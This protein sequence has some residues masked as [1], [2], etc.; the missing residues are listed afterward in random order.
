MSSALESSKEFFWKV[1]KWESYTFGAR[2]FS[3]F[4]QHIPFSC[5]VS[6]AKDT[7]ATLWKITA[8]ARTASAMSP[9][10]LQVKAAR[11]GCVTLHI[12]LCLA[13][14]CDTFPALTAHTHALPPAWPCSAERGL[15]KQQP[16]AISQWEAGG[17]WQQWHPA[18]QG[19][20]LPETALSMSCCKNQPSW[21]LFL[22]ASCLAAKNTTLANQP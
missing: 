5:S 17:P 8:P 18:E 21:S 15:C 13:H 22:I 12:S 6:V 20:T 16:A 10:P 11:L 9:A 4:T 3:E 7:E 14:L 2:S 19:K 1:E